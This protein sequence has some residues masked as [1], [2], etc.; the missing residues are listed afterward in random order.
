MAFTFLFLM[1]GVSYLLLPVVLVTEKTSLNSYLPYLLIAFSFP[2]FVATYNLWFERVRNWKREWWPLIFPFAYVGVFLLSLKGMIP[3][4]IFV[5]VKLSY[6]YLIYHFCQQLYGV[7]LWMSG[8][9]KIVISKGVRRLLRVTF[10]LVGFFSI[11]EMEVRGATEILFYMS[12]PIVPMPTI[13]VQVIFGLTMAC[14]LLTVLVL[15][16]AFLKLK[17]LGA[18]LPLAALGVAWLWFIPPFSH[19]MVYFLP[20]AHGLQYYPF[21]FMKIRSRPVWMQS[22]VIVSSFI[23]GWILFRWLPFTRGMGILSGTVWTT[24][25]LTLLNNHHFIIDGRIWKLRD[26]SNKDVTFFPE[27]QSQEAKVPV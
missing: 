11:L 22:L 15:F 6:F 25:V 27:L 7:A 16:L 5:I 21:I 19:H 13:F 23:F 4:P 20:V 1:V 14:S 2:H 3:L 8:L 17:R 26:P 9:Q 10:L 12:T 24:L 18:F